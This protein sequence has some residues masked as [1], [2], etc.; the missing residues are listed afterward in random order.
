MTK[1]SPALALVL[2]AF[3]LAGCAGDD[4]VNPLPPPDASTSDASK[5][6]NASDGARVHDAADGEAAAAAD[7]ATLGSRDAGPDGPADAAPDGD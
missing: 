5:D 1:T 3:L 4:T 2:G 6:A 7:A